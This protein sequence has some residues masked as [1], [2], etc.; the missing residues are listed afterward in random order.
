MSQ[1]SNKRVMRIYRQYFDLIKNG[2]KTIEVRVA[3]PSMK[4]ITV[5]T[6]ILFND[7]PGCTCRV[8]RVAQ[9]RTFDDMM[10]AEDPVKINPTLSARQQLADMKKIFPPEK[11]KLGVIIFEF[12]KV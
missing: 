9:Y 4:S 10:A 6:L 8:K 1:G 7:D 11:E 2:T 3:Y 5:G 12:K